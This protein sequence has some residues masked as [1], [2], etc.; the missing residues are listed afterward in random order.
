MP[1]G[2]SLVGFVTSEAAELLVMRDALGAEHRVAKSAIE[3]RSKLPTSVMPEG[4]VADLS[5]AQFAS[6]LD[7]I[8]GMKIQ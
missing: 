7:F 3:E 4:L 8:A 1:L 5:I 6:L 2:R